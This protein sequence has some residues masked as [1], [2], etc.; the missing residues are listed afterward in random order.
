MEDILRQLQ[1][2]FEIRI[3]PEFTSFLSTRVVRDRKQKKLWICMDQYLEKL[4]TL[5]ELEYHKLSDTPLSTQELVPFDGE[6]T[7]SQIKAYQRRIGSII[8]PASTVRPD[9]AFGASKLAEFMMNPSP[10]HL[11]EANRMITYLYKTRYQAIEYSAVTMDNLEA[12]SDASF[13]DD[14]MTRRSS[15]GYLIKLFNGPI[16]WQASRQK[17]VTTSTT[18]AELLALSYTGREIQFLARIFKAIRLDIDEDLS[19]DCDN[20]QTVRIVTQQAPTISTKLRHVD[21]HQFWLRQQVTS[22]KYQVKWVPTGEM[23]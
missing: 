10:S 6:A 23:A 12:A 8:Y 20:Q 22:G 3:L 19:I 1:D 11:A 2:R 15:Q 18:E 5:Y 16:A 7:P 13:A 9:V 17:T 21:I 14:S 4:L